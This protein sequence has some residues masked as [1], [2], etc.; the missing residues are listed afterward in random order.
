MSPTKTKAIRRLVD[1]LC[2][3]TRNQAEALVDAFAIPDEILQA[4]IAV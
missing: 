1:Q 4:P 2:K 3:E